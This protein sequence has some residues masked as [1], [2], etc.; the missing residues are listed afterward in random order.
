MTHDPP[1][2]VPSM[3]SRPPSRSISFCQI[4]GRRAIIA[5]ET[6]PPIECARMRTGCDVS[7]SF[8]ATASPSRAPSSTIERRQSNGNS[9]TSCDP[10][11]KRTTRSYALPTSAC[12]SMPGAS[13]PS[14]RNLPRA[15]SQR[16]IQMRLPAGPRCEP[17][18]PGTTNTTGRVPG[19]TTAG[20]R[21][22][23]SSAVASVIDSKPASLP[24]GRVRATCTFSAV[25]A[26][27]K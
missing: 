18:M 23:S 19:T 4:S 3:M 8:A 9:T 12:A 26:L 7:P 6:R 11:R 2:G 24:S 20:A 13:I 15:R 25:S 14:V 10:Q 22:F 16:S 1:F 27:R 21:D 17:M 5:R